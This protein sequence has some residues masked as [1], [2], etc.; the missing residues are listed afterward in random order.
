MHQFGFL[1]TVHED[2]FFCTSL[3]TF[4]ICAF[5]WWQPFWQLWGDKFLWFRFVFPWGLV[6][7]NIF[8]CVLAIPKSSLKNVYRVLCPQFNYVV[9]LILN[10]MNSLYILNM[11]PL[12]DISFTHIFF[13]SVGGHFI[14]LMFS[15]IGKKVFSWML[16]HLF[17][18]TFHSLAWGDRLKEKYC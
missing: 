8:S 16:S 14:L 5:F 9:F 3:P 13:H 2:S 17:I 15:F 4:V 1:P 10:F 7:L 18:F 12:L 6:M 11:N